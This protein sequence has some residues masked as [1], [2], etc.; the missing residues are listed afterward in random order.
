MATSTI[1]MMVS[2]IT[3]TKGGG[4]HV[5]LFSFYA[6]PSRKGPK[7]EG[8]SCMEKG[9]NMTVSTIQ[10]KLLLKYVK[11][12]TYQAM[13]WF[14]QAKLQS[15]KGQNGKISNIFLRALKLR[16]ITA[17]CISLCWKHQKMPHS[18]LIAASTRSH[19][20]KWNPAMI[21]PQTP[22]F[23]PRGHLSGLIQRIRRYM[24]TKPKCTTEI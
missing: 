21:D 6:F 15:T 11:L 24:V 4:H 2:P 8:H 12:E 16:Q 23:L 20:P 3:R 5:L 7:R 9:I 19:E 18:F 10:F 14:S 17:S 1:A 22:L 13:L